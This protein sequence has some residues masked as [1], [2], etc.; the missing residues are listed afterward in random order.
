MEAGLGISKHVDR[1]C[2]TKTPVLILK[3]TVRW[4]CGHELLGLKVPTAQLPR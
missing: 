4:V 1:S 3:A 2:P